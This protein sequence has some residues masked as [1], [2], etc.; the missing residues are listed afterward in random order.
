MGKV[1]LVCLIL[2]GVML[3]GCVGEEPAA[4]DDTPLS[5]DDAQLASGKGGIAGLLVDDRFRPLQLVDD[6]LQDY[7]AAGFIL[8]QETGQQVRSNADGEF[9]VVGLDPG[10]YTLRVTASGHEATPQRVQV[11]VGEFTEL[12]IVARRIIN[13]D[14]S[15]LTQ[16]FA[17][18]VPCSVGYVLQTFVYNCATDGSGQNYRPGFISDYRT[19]ENVTYLVTEMKAV[20]KH[21]YS[22]QVR[23]ADAGAQGGD[24]FVVAK[25]WD[26]DYIKM[27]LQYGVKNEE[28][29]AQLRNVPW[30]NTVRLNTI[31][32]P[33]PPF[34]NEVNDVL[35]P[36]CVRD[37]DD[38]TREVWDQ[39]NI[40]DN[41]GG[42]A[43]QPRTCDRSWWGAGAGLAYRARFV[44]SLFIGEPEVNMDAYCII[45]GGD[46]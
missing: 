23:E 2:V 34:T 46:P 42:Y 41:S 7:Q 20:D 30:N 21:V 3:S 31:M 28:H 14:G 9:L 44:Q 32:F 37:L 43:P 6:P 24:R 5:R 39:G 19:I 27:T 35:E 15:V 33:A 18:F 38:V 13:M 4:L 40:Y 12:S 16:E 8:I 26:E 22:I 25:I 29:D 10:S 45:C 11:Q 1:V 36:G 17:V